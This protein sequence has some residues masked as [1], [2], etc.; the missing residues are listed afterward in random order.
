MSIR[1]DQDDYLIIIYLIQIFGFVKID[2]RGHII[3]RITFQSRPSQ[4]LYPVITLLRLVAVNVNP[5]VNIRIMMTFPV[6]RT[7][8][9]AF[10]RS[11]SEAC[12]KNDYGQD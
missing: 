5:R 2:I 10:I 6:I 11:T 1:L 7:I 3:L 9:A 8:A 12:D 4:Y